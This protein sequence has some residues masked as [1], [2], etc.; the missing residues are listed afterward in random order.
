MFRILSYRIVLHVTVLY[1]HRFQR[2]NFETLYQIGDT[3]DNEG[4][5]SMKKAFTFPFHVPLNLRSWLGAY[6]SLQLHTDLKN[7]YD[8]P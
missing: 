4:V 8:P 2:V 1:V 7:D 5:E 6:N 3:L